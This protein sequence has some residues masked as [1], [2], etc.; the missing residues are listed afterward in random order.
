M[1]MLSLGF[2]RK[3]SAVEERGCSVLD[4]GLETGVLSVLTGQSWLTVPPS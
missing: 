4:A 3:R 1:V 2:P